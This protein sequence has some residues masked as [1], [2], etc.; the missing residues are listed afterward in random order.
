MKF[1]DVDRD[2]RG[3]HHADAG[4]AGLANAIYIETRLSD[5]RAELTKIFDS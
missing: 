4:V 2:A 5:K 1:T 3:Q